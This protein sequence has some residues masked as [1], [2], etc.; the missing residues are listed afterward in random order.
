[1][2]AAL[3]HISISTNIKQEFLYMLQLVQFLD[4]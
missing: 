3:G 1:M 4:K 2:P